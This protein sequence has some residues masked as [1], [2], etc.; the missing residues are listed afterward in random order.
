[1]DLTAD[2]MRL[3]FPWFKMDFIDHQREIILICL[4]ADSH[5]EIRVHFDKNGRIKSIDSLPKIYFKCFHQRI[6][7]YRP[8]ILYECRSYST[9]HHD[10]YRSIFKHE[11]LLDPTRPLTLP[12]QKNIIPIVSYSIITNI[13]Q[14]NDIEVHVI[15]THLP[16]HYRND[17]FYKL[18]C[19][20]G[21][22]EQSEQERTIEM[23]VRENKTEQ[24]NR[25]KLRYIIALATELSQM[26]D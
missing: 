11:T 2:S 23:H 4:N 14:N 21:Y 10:N 3:V 15:R 19:I 13:F 25:E 7:P 22:I 8:D 6:S 16:I 26:L 20:L 17:D 9:I 12:L 24:L 1:M 5:D 18:R